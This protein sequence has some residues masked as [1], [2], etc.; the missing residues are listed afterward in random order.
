MI[1][2]LRHREFFDASKY[3]ST[4][5]I[6]GAGAVGSRVFASLIELG[7]TKIKVYDFD[8]VERHNVANQI[9]GE[10]QCGMSKVAALQEWAQHKAPGLPRTHLDFR[11]EKV[12]PGTALRGTVFLLVDSMKERR[13]IYEGCIQDNIDVPRVI[14]VRMAASHGEVY[15][16]N[17]HTQGNAWLNT[18][19]DDDKAEVSG[20]GS[21]FSVAPTAA[22]LANLAVWQYMLAKSDPAAVDE[23]VR[24]FLHPL[25]IA[26]SNLP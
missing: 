16:F 19:I 14:E 12:V 8:V 25:T 22:I 13:R 7:F 1:D 24:V 18:L 23:I 9:Y 4:T 3:N 20:C 10:V 2:T 5:S 17:P 26:T 6:V 15:T 21:P 11:S